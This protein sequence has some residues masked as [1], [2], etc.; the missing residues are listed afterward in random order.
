LNLYISRL[1]KPCFIRPKSQ[2]SQGLRSGEQGGCGARTNLRC[3]ISAPILLPSWHRELS[4]SRRKVPL[5][6]LRWGKWPENT[7]PWSSWL[8]SR[9][10]WNRAAGR[11]L[12]S[13][14]Y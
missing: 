8:T 7:S 13:R 4:M 10:D 5:E 1:F 12:F 3:S 2:K 6:C 14:R 9:R 11:L